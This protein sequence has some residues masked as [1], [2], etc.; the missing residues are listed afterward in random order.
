M[1]TAATEAMRAVSNVAFELALFEF[2][3]EIQVSPPEGDFSESRRR[4]WIITERPFPD[5]G[6]RSLPCCFN[7]I[8]GL[9]FW[10]RIKAGDS[11]ER[12]ATLIRHLDVTAP[13]HLKPRQI[14]TLAETE[15]EAEAVK[16]IPEPKRGRPQTASKGFDPNRLRGCPNI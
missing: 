16:P 8:R 15:E 4:V 9:L 12:A 13:S 1:R 2:T 7:C 6:V 10:R 3:S 11:W 14:R 5:H